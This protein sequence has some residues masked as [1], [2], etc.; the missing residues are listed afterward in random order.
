MF[1]QIFAQSKPFVDITGM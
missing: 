1:Q